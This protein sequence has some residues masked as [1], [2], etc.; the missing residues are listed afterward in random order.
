MSTEHAAPAPP[1]EEAVVRYNPFAPIATASSLKGLLE[2]NRQSIASILPRHVTV[3]RLIKTMLV[4]T[5]RNPALL[6]CTQGSIIETIQRAAELG[7]D[8]SG[9]L[10]EAYPVPF[11]NKIKVPQADGS[12]REVFVDQC[13]FI[14]GYRGLAKLA[15]QS[16]EVA[17][18]EA[19]AV[20]SGDH[21]VY[22]KGSDFRLEFRPLLA[23]DRGALQ[24]FYAYVKLKDGGQQA[25]YMTVAEVERIRQ[26]SKAANGP[27]WTNDFAEMG[28]KTVFKRLAKWL[29]LSSE[30][31][32]DAV[33]QDNE[34]EFGDTSFSDSAV[35]DL[36][37][38]A[39]QEVPSGA[40]GAAESPEKAK[41]VVLPSPDPKVDHRLAQELMDRAKDRGATDAEIEEFL[42][43]KVHGVKTFGE[44]PVAKVPIIESW[45]ANLQ[46]KE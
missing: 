40:P 30:K 25:E 44:V 27:A 15:R 36:P 4:A 20:F 16:G 5:N 9:T 37:A 39:V 13:Q 38:S 35:I 41:A 19:E 2:R 8:L 1:Q 23:G 6:K 45:L 10:G 33:T 31:F 12:T 11:R 28:R 32:T 22:Q 29:N 7:L 46:G 17:H 34:V 24:G 3:E 14:P 42:M 18:L 43:T 26:R 21:F